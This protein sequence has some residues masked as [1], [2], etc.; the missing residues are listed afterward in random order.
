MNLT[1]E[2][3][4]QPDP[5]KNGTRCNVPKRAV[6]AMLRK[7]VCST[8][9]APG[10]SVDVVPVSQVLIDKW[11]P[12]TREARAES[13]QAGLRCKMSLEFQFHRNHVSYLMR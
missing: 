1:S 4:V 8:R 2:C 6:L 3:R 5:P 7:R 11:H 13:H 12:L 9:R 10:T